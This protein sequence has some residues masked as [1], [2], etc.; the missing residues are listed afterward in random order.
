MR[1]DLQSHFDY[2]RWWCV[3]ALR[4]CHELAYKYQS[5]SPTPTATATPTPIAKPNAKQSS[6]RVSS[7]FPRKSKPRNAE[8]GGLVSCCNW[9]SVSRVPF[10]LAA[11]LNPAKLV[12][13]TNERTLNA[14]FPTPMFSY[15][16]SVSRLPFSPSPTSLVA[17]V[18]MSVD[19]CNSG[20]CRFHQGLMRAQS[21]AQTKSIKKITMAFIL[22]HVFRR[23]SLG[24]FYCTLIEAAGGATPPSLSGCITH[25]Y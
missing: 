7:G 14:T 9:T 6:D 11:S 4:P 1:F 12:R 16:A 24:Q 19:N 13:Q 22:C 2:N 10:L 25:M 3:C 15:S 18:L 8:S 23:R 20:V 21:R 5:V 17:I